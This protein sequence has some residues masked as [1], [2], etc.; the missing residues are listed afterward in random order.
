MFVRLDA[1]R[2]RPPDLVVVE[3]AAVS[4]DRDLPAARPLERRQPRHRDDQQ[5]NHASA[6]DDQDGDPLDATAAINLHRSGSP[7]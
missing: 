5:G 4:D 7:R 3:R 6:C 1:L 2:Q